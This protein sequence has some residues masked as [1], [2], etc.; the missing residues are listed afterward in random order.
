MRHSSITPIIFLPKPSRR[1]DLDECGDDLTILLQIIHQT[2][3]HQLERYRLARTDGCD[4]PA[5]ILD[6][7]CLDLIAQVIHVPIMRIKCAAVDIRFAHYV[8]HGDALEVLL[9][10]AASVPAAQLFV[11]RMRLSSTSAMVSHS[12]HI[13]FPFHFRNLHFNEHI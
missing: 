8:G 1:I 13:V 5:E 11:R 2:A 4:H 10:I 12:I 6:H 9:L 7:P 3:E